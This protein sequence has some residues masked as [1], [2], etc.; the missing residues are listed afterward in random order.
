MNIILKN[1]ILDALK[2]EYPSIPE[3]YE[4][5]DSNEQPYKIDNNALI[6]EISRSAGA[7]GLVD[8]EYTYREDASESWTQ[9]E[10]YSNK[11]QKTIILCYEAEQMF[12]DLDDIATALADYQE[13]ADKLEE[14][15]TINK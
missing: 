5:I 8:V 11:L 10:Y 12:R 13:Q 3:I 14:S 6:C 1:K 9:V 4:P 2:K 7:L 15:I